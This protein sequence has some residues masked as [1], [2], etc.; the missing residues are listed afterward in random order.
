V[1]N[2]IRAS[3]TQADLQA[4]ALA[5]AS[6]SG[7][8]LPVWDDIDAWSYPGTGSI[9]NEQSL[10]ASGTPYGFCGVATDASGN[11]YICR[12]TGSL[13]E[14]TSGGSASVYSLPSGV[15]YVG[16]AYLQAEALPYVINAS[17]AIS[18]L[19][20]AAFVPVSPDPA[21]PD[22]VYALAGS[23][24]VLAT[25]LPSLSGVG[26][27]TLSSSGA[28]TSGFF[29]A[30][31]ISN[32]TCLAV[33]SGEVTIAVGGWNQA[34]FGSGF[35]AG[36]LAAD[37]Q[38]SALLLGATSGTISLLS[39]VSG[40]VSLSQSISGVAAPNFVSWSANGASGFA[41]DPT[42]G[43]VYVLNYGAS[44][45]T[46]AQ[47]L[48]LYDASQAAFDP[49]NLY[50]L[51]TQPG[52]GLVTVL[53]YSGSWASGQTIALS[54]ATSVLALGSGSAAIGYASGLAYLTLSGS[55]WTVSASAA[56][57]FLPSSLA[58]GLPG[59]I[60]AVGTSGSVGCLAEL[61]G[62]SV[63]ASGSWNGSADQILWVQGQIVISD[64][65]SGLLRLFEPIYSSGG[66]T[67]FTFV[68]A[69]GGPLN[70]VN[71]SGGPLLW[72]GGFVTSYGPSFQQTHT[73]SGPSTG[74]GAIAFASPYLIACSGSVGQ[75]F[76]FAAPYALAP[77]QSGIVS[78]YVASAW[79]SAQLGP[80][81]TPECLAFDVS[82]N[83]SVA[84]LQNTFFTISPSG[85]ITAS[86][87]ILQADDQPQT[88]PIGISALLWTAGHLYGATSLND[89]LVQVV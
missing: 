34:S 89:S 65:A 42:S 27:F 86:G 46:L 49:G 31:G 82:G 13:I 69:S 75:M 41:C 80:L 18:V 22:S 68:N 50:A 2:F 51:V 21:F 84:T 52:S 66:L 39:I 5:A 53:D 73:Y 8:L 37:P 25:L 12:H 87:S 1:S 40:V 67:E 4:M 77:V 33:G 36:G 20:G 7:V 10:P 74:W 88:T 58:T 15:P 32:L 72:T 47:T 81:Q 83:V 48:S 43:H 24:S 54:G 3:N 76:Q 55:T 64:R 6:A 19:S 78:A 16:V 71:A 85:S 30:S 9:L 11:A 62:G 61:S 70:F 26:L 57:S 28:G 56:L 14:L 60:Y 63:V 38:N 79:A 44:T 59:T 23:G 35:A 29:G 17:G 45:L